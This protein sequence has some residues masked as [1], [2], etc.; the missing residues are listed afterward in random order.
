MAAS[1]LPQTE[2]R[3]VA[4]SPVSK[5]VVLVIDVQNF[6]AKRQ[7]SEFLSRTVSE[8]YWA[9]V[10]RAIAKAARVLKA[11]RCAGVEVMYTTIESLTI[12]GRDRSLDYKISGFNI[13][14]GTWDGRVV[15]ELAPVGDEM[16]FPKTSCSVFQSTNLSYVLRNLECKQLII[17]GGLTDQCVESAVRDACD[18]GFLV[19]LITDACYTESAERH[20]FALRTIKGYC[21]QRTADQVEVELKANFGATLAVKESAP[22][23]H[24]AKYVRFEITDINAKSLCKVLPARHAGVDSVYFY[25]G[26]MAMGPNAELLC[27]PDEVANAG[28]PN[29][30]AIPMW[31]TAQRVPWTP[32]PTTRVLCELEHC[33]AV[34]RAL[35]RMLLNELKAKHGIEILAAAEYEFTL[36][37]NTDEGWQPAFDGVDIFATLQFQKQASLIYEIEAKMLEAGIDVKTMNCE[38]G[39]GQIEIT[40]A[41]KMGI[42]A[43]DAASTFKLGVKE[44]AASNGLRASFMTKPFGINAVGNG[45]HFN[46]SLWKDGVNITGDGSDKELS[47]LARRWI[48]GIMYH[49]RA[50][51]ALCA[52]TPPCYERHGHWAPTHAN[53]GVEDRMCAVRAKPSRDNPYLEL[54]LPSASSNAYLVIAALAAAGMHG[55]EADADAVQSCPPNQEGATALPTSLAEALD[56]LKADAYLVNKLGPDFVRWFDLLKRNEIES[57]QKYTAEFAEARKSSQ[58]GNG[59]LEPNDDDIKK[60]WQKMYMEYL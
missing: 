51:E 20:D 54:R 3:E 49:S 31:E 1:F 34:P 52:P 58:T 24:G 10:D 48:D 45:G 56:A 59:H 21:R 7:G 36:A 50:I 18:L 25:S 39:H 22:V 38:Y 19:T 33:P 57:I 8:Y 2:L 27:F 35:C 46:H 13:P 53:W 42:A 43:G 44:L 26:I 32:V 4:L 12:D 11:A 23:L 37:K 40:Y 41:P 9:A 14:K 28:C 15:E 60:G 16:V 5:P 17:C 6:C 30:K 55:L 29:W 47:G